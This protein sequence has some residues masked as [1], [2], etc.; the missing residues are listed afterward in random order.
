[1][2]FKI[3]IIASL[4]IINLYFIYKSN[5]KRKYGI[6]PGRISIIITSIFCI[7]YFIIVVM[8]TNNQIPKTPPKKKTEISYEEYQ[9]EL[10]EYWNAY[11]KRENKL[12]IHFSILQQIYFATTVQM[13]IG[14]VCCIYGLIMIKSRKNFYL[15]T[16]GLFLA[17]I[18]TTIYLDKYI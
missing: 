6:F 11:A 17:A 7:Y 2:L 3:G 13:G 9:K 8:S 16:T 18:I 12:S 14:L 1:M 15:A 4:I 5:R 10:N